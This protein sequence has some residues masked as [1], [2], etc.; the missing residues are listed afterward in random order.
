M[1]CL[2]INSNLK[3]PITQQKQEC[4]PVGCVLSAA[5]AV[6]SGG[7]VCSRVGLLLE[8]VSAPGAVCLLW[9][10]CVCSGRGVCSWGAV[11]PSMHWGRPPPPVERMTDRCKNITFAVSHD[12]VSKNRAVWQLQHQ[13]FLWLH[14]SGCR[15]HLL[16]LAE[17]ACHHYINCVL[18]FCGV[19]VVGIVCV[20]E[21]KLHCKVGFFTNRQNWQ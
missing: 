19:V 11:Y 8:G 2:Q 4:I 14:V 10:V 20:C 16:W 17:V 18:L 21:S 9:G 7:G 3:L 1:N 6:C 5:V 15:V 13:Q 12:V